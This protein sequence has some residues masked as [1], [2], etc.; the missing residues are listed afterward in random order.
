MN[1]LVTGGAGFI[2]FSLCRQLLK[3]GDRLVIIDNLNDYYDVRLKL[4]RLREL[5]IN[6]ANNP[7]KD[8]MQ[9]RFASTTNTTKEYNKQPFSLTADSLMGYKKRETPNGQLTF[10]KSDITDCHALTRIFEQ[11]HFDLVCNLAAQAGVRYSLE[12]PNAYLLSNILG[13][14]NVLE[15]CRQYGVERVVFASSSSVYGNNR[16][17]PFCENDATEQPASIYACTKKMDELMAYT[18][19]HLYGLRCTGMRFFTVYGPWGRPDMSPVLFASAL[20]KKQPINVF[21]NGQMKRDFTYIDDIVD[22]IIRCIDIPPTG[23]PPF[24]VYNLGNARPIAL[25]DF[26]AAIEHALGTTAQLNMLPMQP[27]DVLETYADITKAHQQLGYEPHFS[28]DEGISRFAEWYRNYYE[29]TFV[30][31]K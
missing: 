5:G 24:I 9:Q 10:I 20:T 17:V 27:G 1:I 25:L 22:G 4:A 16:K 26:I 13:F 31:G 28:L 29:K 3:R 2:G 15:A 18:Y 23:Q 6:I 8:R 21:N 14:E 30:L 12:N 19:S 7:T 11:Y